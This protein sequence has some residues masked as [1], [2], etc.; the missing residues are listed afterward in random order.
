M[1]LPSLLVKGKLVSRPGMTPKEV[2]NLKNQIPLDYIIQ[3]L[4]D[5]FPEFGAKP[6]TSLNDLVFIIRAKTGSGK[7]T[8]MPVE[9]YRMFNPSVFSIKEYQVRY[10]ADESKKTGV[11]KVIE[12]A[13]RQEKLITSLQGTYKGKNILCTQPRVLTAMSIPQELTSVDSVWSKD[14]LFGKTI[15]FSTGARKITCNNCLMY[16]TLDTLLGQLKTLTDDTICDLYRVI[17][18]DEVHERSITLDMVIMLLKRLLLNKVGDPNCPFVIFTSATFDVTKYAEYLGVDISTNVIDVEGLTYDIEDTYLEVSTTNYIDKV[19]ELIE[20]I[21]KTDEYDT[22]GNDMLVFTPG[23]AAVREIRKVLEPVL[24]KIIDGP[25]PKDKDGKELPKRTF[26]FVDVQR[27]EVNTTKVFKYLE[28][29]LDELRMNENGE[30]DDKGT[31]VPYR[32][33]FTGTTVVETGITINTLAYIFET[34]F[35]NLQEKYFPFNIGGVL[36]KPV[37]KSRVVQRRGRVGRKFPGK[38]YYIYTEDTYNK[39]VDIQLPNIITE[40]IDRHIVEI[41]RR[42]YKLNELDMLDV[43]PMVSLKSSMTDAIVSGVIDYDTLELTPLGQRFN[44]CTLLTL[45]QFR[46]IRSAYIYGVYIPDIITILAMCSEDGWRRPWKMNLKEIFSIS[47]PRFFDNDEELF[48]T[49]TLDKFIEDLFIFNA[50]KSKC[51]TN[52]ITEVMDWCTE[53][54][55]KYEDFIDLIKLRTDL[56]K[57]VAVLSLNPL[58]GD[59]YE[60]GNSTIKNYLDIVC[61][62]KR[63][64]YD[65]FVKNTLTFDKNSFQYFDRFG[66]KV[67]IRGI[68]PS[69]RKFSN[70]IVT[71][72]ITL[73]S[74]DQATYKQVIEIDR[75]SV[76]DGYVDFD[77]GYLEPI[78][79]K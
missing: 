35:T 69:V 7:S 4:K 54:K 16:V 13:L 55:L 39:L 14:M 51:T 21:N 49:V 20:N 31:I 32:R 38:A 26:M 48:T 73:K 2:Q 50:F 37:A 56:M 74:A 68:P 29:P 10:E 61:N 79:T 9:I 65:G 23:A 42:G 64:L 78:V 67:A 70:H 47:L 46:V 25:A 41:L 40:G 62:I 24:K 12:K 59:E 76:L 8:A 43:P 22:R 71:N 52:T 44:K 15:G 63:C 45:Q 1:P 66:N 30:P 75:W 58:Y 18:L 36:Q 6:A 57:D 60:M 77:L 53:M 19:G 27:K 72:K 33:I 28:S 3:R 34:G 11:G 17:I 5:K